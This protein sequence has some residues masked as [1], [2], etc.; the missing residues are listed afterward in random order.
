MP[1]WLVFILL[2]QE[3]PQPPVEPKAPEPSWLAPLH[4]SLQFKYRGRLTSDDRDN[5]LYAWVA[6]RYGDPERDAITASVSA[7][8][9]ADIDGDRHNDGFYAF[10]SRDD[11]YRRAQTAR[12]YTAYVDLHRPLP[13][14][15]VRGGRQVLED[16]PEAVPMDGALARYR[17]GD[18]VAF[19]AFGGL[20]VNPFESSTQSDRMYGAWVEATPGARTRVRVE[21]LHIRD[22]NVFG[23]FKDDLLGASV[24]HRLG[25]LLG[26][27]RYTNLEGDSRD[28]TAGVTGAFSEVG[29]L[30]NA[31]FTYVFEEI[32]TLSYPLD[33][34]TVVLLELKP[35][36][37]A[38]LTASKTLGPRFVVDASVTVRELE[39]EGDEADY[40]HEFL[41]WNVSPRTSDW[42]V[43]GVSIAVT[44]DFW[45]TSADDFWTVGGDAT[46][47]VHPDVR[48]SAGTSFTL[49][50]IDAATGEERER[51]RSIYAGVRW[52]FIKDTSLDVRVSL[53]K[54]EF[55]TFTTIE[56]GVRRAF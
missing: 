10:D 25:A 17:I 32:Q 33:P 29:F 31:Q 8:F 14:L 34:F 40:N 38:T 36:W 46:W 47:Q 9:A 4:G 44:V 15:F 42:P 7:R 13:G 22:E 53:D 50:T 52:K 43:R 39:E 12:L 49:Y 54:D 56:V 5:D 37:Q 30:V 26:R 3:Q 27:V 41:R 55:D 21:Y 11:T 45:Q 16:F 2:A 24:E 1:V 18:V 6:A 23:A 20:P 35:Y 28:V 19:G 51:V 48:V